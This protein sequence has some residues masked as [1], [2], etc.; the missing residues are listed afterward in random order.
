M[1]DLALLMIA[2]AAIVAGIAAWLGSLLGEKLFGPSKARSIIA[3]IFGVGSIP[4][5]NG[6]L[7]PILQ[8]IAGPYEA[9]TVMK[10]SP[11]FDVIFKYHPDALRC[12]WARSQNASI[13]F[14]SSRAGM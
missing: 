13:L 2:L 9:I 3:T 1:N 14:G 7:V 12:G 11:V 10:R 5:T 6:T 4:L 8:Q